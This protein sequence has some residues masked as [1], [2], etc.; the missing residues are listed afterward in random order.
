MKTYNKQFF[1]SLGE[2]SLESARQIVPIILE[3]IKPK[4][5][6]D[7]GCG[8]GAWLKAF[9]ENGVEDILG[10]DGSYMN[11]KL[12]MISKESFLTYDLTK[13]ITLK[14]TFDLAISLEVAEHLPEEYAE[15]FVS[16]LTK[17]S[18]VIVFSGAIPFQGGTNHVNEQWAEYWKDLFEK[19]GY[20]LIDCLRKRI[21]NNPKVDYFYA[22]NM[23]F[24][25]EKSNLNKLAKL[26][27]EL[28][29][30]MPLNLVHPKRYVMMGKD[31]KRISKYIP[32]FIKKLVR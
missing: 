2:T 10:I 3:Y 27:N 8:V 9:E 21:W 15:T 31:R 1:E 29:N 28:K 24:F 7:V 18:R 32:K 12:L 4:S 23:F 22:Q 20:V 26:K 11:R 6:I 30:N 14:G 16:S 5:V 25:V 19:K 13:P 17:L